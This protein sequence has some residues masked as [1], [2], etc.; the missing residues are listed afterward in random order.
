MDNNEYFDFEEK[1]DFPFYKNLSFSTNTIVLA[2]SVI[3]FILLVFLPIHFQGYQQQIIFCLAALI[4]FL[5]ATNGNWGYLFKKPKMRDIKTVIIALIGIFVTL[6]IIT[7]I[8]MLL[9][10]SAMID[11]GNS[12][13]I[14]LNLIFFITEFIQII[15]EE[16]F[17]IMSF[18][19]IMAI[20]YRLTKHNRKHSLIIATFSTLLLFGL[21]HVNSYSSILYCI[22]VMGFGSI[23]ELY[24]YLKTKNILLAIIVHFL[25]NLIVLLINY[26]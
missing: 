7:I 21:M 11:S 19:F 5:V 24:P 9:G 16:I 4:P 10:I 18:I 26:V 14:T 2:L 22:F 17:K 25:Y 1:E 6:F 12:Y 20:S 3:L 15:G 8:S 13:T 23:M